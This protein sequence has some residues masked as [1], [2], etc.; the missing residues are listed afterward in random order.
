MPDLKNLKKVY[1]CLN[2][3]VQIKEETAFSLISPSPFLTGIRGKHHNF[4]LQIWNKWQ[5]LQSHIW[6]SL[7]KEIRV[8]D[9]S[10]LFKTSPFSIQFLNIGLDGAHL[11]PPSIGV[12]YEAHQSSQPVPLQ[13]N[14]NCARDLHLTAILIQSSHSWHLFQDPTIKQQGH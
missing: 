1:T 11:A 14:A 5:L 12:E 7:R 9:F 6:E 10:F 8:W 13:G 3:Q 4:P 2:K